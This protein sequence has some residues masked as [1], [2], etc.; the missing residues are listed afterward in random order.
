MVERH[1]VE[2]EGRG[3]QEI[4]EVEEMKS[5]DEKGVRVVVGDVK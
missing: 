4:G 3:R 2:S 5:R 1:E